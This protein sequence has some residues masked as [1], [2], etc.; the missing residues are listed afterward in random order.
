MQ[1][2]FQDLREVGVKAVEKTFILAWR[3][4]GR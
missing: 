1:A 4:G 2:S 3:E